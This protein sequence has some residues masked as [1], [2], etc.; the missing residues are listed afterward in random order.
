MQ[1]NMLWGEVWLLPL[2]FCPI[3]Q[4]TVILDNPGVG[5]MKQEVCFL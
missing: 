2:G 5:K 1:V 3:V 4:V